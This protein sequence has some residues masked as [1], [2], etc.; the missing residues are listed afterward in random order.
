MA[1]LA[2]CLTLTGRPCFYSRKSFE[3]FLL[4]S[5]QVTEFQLEYLMH[6]CS[7][8]FVHYGN[9]NLSSSLIHQARIQGGGQG[10]VP[11]PLSPSETCHQ[12]SDQYVQP[13]MGFPDFSFEFSKC[14]FFWAHLQL[15]LLIPSRYSW[16][17]GRATRYN[18]SGPAVS[19]A[20]QLTVK[21][22]LMA[23]GNA[24]RP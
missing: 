21:W 5:V 18:L 19:I 7:S 2:P 24:S 23:W 1:H 14:L 11:P 10:A 4:C 16:T 3:V 8:D 17:C 15:L 13:A 6:A 22:P 20:K 9:M 12:T